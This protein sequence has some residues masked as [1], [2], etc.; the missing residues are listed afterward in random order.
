LD[1]FYRAV[2][3]NYGI[4]FFVYTPEEFEEMNKKN[5]FL[6]GAVKK[7]RLLYENRADG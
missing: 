4:D 5:L 1:E 7:G 2:K 3:P 6:R